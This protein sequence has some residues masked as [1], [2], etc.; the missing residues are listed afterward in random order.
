M[1]SKGAIEAEDDEP[2]RKIE[3]SWQGGEEFF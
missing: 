2:K 1:G 3:F